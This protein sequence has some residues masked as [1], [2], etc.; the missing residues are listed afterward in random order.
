MTVKTSSYFETL[1]QGHFSPRKLEGD[2]LVPWHGSVPK[3][4]GIIIQ[5][6]VRGGPAFER[7]KLWT[8]KELRRVDPN[9]LAVH[10]F[11]TPNAPEQVA[12]EADERDAIDP[13]VANVKQAL[14]AGWRG[15]YINDCMAD[16]GLDELRA[17]IKYMKLEE[18][19]QVVAPAETSLRY[20]VD[21]YGKFAII[22][23]ADTLPIFKRLS[24]KY[25]VDGDLVLTLLDTNITPAQ[26]EKEKLEE[27]ARSLGNNIV[28]ARRLGANA[29]VFGCTTLGGGIVDH[30]REL[31]P[32]LEEF[33][34]IE[35][36]PIT[37]KQAV[38]VLHNLQ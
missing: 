4:L 9:V 7:A 18:S 23:I 28:K 32:D 37:L 5:S 31:Y 38:Q 34:L 17:L 8:L 36:M 15:V 1:P 27:A 29:V 24:Q 3:Q 25:G 12:C 26:L 14:Q 19:V 20:A 2:T 10:S 11:S 22:G 6:V 16:P 13:V 30:I 21:T 33:P 35:P